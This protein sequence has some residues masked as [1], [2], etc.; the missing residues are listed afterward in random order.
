MITA[1]ISMDGA[2]IEGRYTSATLTWDRSV[3][4]D[5][6]QIQGA[7]P[8]LYAQA[9]PDTNPGTARISV[10]L[11][12]FYTC[13]FL[14]EERSGEAHA[15]TI[16]GRGLSALDEAEYDP[17]QA[18]ARRGDY[19]SLDAFM[20]AI[21]TRTVTTALHAS[22]DLPEI[23]TAGG[24]PM[25]CLKQAAELVGGIVRGTISGGIAIER[26]YPVAPSLLDGEM[27][28]AELDDDNIQTFSLSRKIGKKY[29]GVLVSCASGE[30]QPQI[31]QESGGNSPTVGL[32]PCYFRVFWPEGEKD[33]T[34]ATW[35]SGGTLTLLSENVYGSFTET[36][37]FQDGQ[38]SVQYPIQEIDSATWSGA[39][40]GT[41]SF[42]AGET[43]LRC[44][45]TGGIAEITYRA[46]YDRYRLQSDSLEQ[47]LVGIARPDDARDLATLVTI[48]SGGTRL[49]DPVEDLMLTNEQ[50]RIER[51]KAVVYDS[52]DQIRISATV[53]A[54]DALMDG[55]IVAV[56][57]P[58]L[59]GNMMIDKA[60]LTIAYLDLK[61][62]LELVRWER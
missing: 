47:I 33:F 9:D 50:A 41:I 52:Y 22:V 6:I 51:G 44:V 7:D 45:G 23:Y 53:L 49:A 58:E 3:P 12:G 14:L 62:N 55:D 39:D 13:L 61:Y 4:H 28:I 32:Y 19:A 27:P 43:E 5:Q 40:G 1:V 29:D 42:E 2:S 26:K 16:S 37:T 31:V 17:D 36:V 60:A 48:P 18:D 56:D 24:Y 34:P 8:T 15:F 54:I 46:Y 30:D 59:T 38:G 10:L 20:S 25:E 35:N 57:C 11:D 21:S